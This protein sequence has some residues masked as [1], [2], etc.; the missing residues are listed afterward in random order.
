MSSARRWITAP[1]AKLLKCRRSEKEVTT[2]FGT[3]P[4]NHNFGKSL[5]IRAIVLQQKTLHE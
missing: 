5:T 2:P 3:H 4:K 1:Q